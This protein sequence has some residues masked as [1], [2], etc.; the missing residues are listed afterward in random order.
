MA[1]APSKNGVRVKLPKTYGVVVRGGIT[2]E[3]NANDVRDA[4]VTHYAFD[5]AD[6]MLTAWPVSWARS[7]DLSGLT[8]LS[9]YWTLGCT[10]GLSGWPS[11]MPAGRTQRLAVGLCRRH[12][13]AAGLGVPTRVG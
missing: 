11:D 8:Q 6:A 2:H 13:R 5:P 1:A 9:T 4:L 10:I 12:G 3:S 7:A